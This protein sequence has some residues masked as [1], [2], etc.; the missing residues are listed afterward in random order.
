MRLNKPNLK[1]HAT[2]EI[3]VAE[4]KRLAGIQ[5]DEVFGVFQMI[6][7]AKPLSPPVEYNEITPQT[8]E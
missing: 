2:K 1:I 7:E 5:Q 6:G 4:A 8:G 3:A